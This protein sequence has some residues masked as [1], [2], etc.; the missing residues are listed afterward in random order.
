MT[1][2]RK[3][4]SYP[5]MPRYFCLS[6]LISQDTSEE[7]TFPFTDAAQID[8]DN[9]LR[10]RLGWAAIDSRDTVCF[11]E[12]VRVVEACPDTGFKRHIFITIPPQAWAP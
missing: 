12:S 3:S 8:E 11:I 6:Q 10:L 9:I 4:L 2:D 5:I 1:F 7:K